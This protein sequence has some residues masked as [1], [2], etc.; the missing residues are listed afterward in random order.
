MALADLLYGQ[1]ENQA[2]GG[3]PAVPPGVMAAPQAAPPQQMQLPPPVVQAP[4]PEPQ[5]PGILDKLRSDPGITQAM[6]MMGAR[7]MQGPKQ[8]QDEYGALGD[9]AMIGLTAHNML[10]QNQIDN[11]LAQQEQ[12]RKNQLAD[13]QIGQVQA[14]TENI[15]LET[16][17]KKESFPETQKRVAAEI[18]RLNTSGEL[19][20]A[21]LLRE[22]Y[23]SDPK[24]L[25]E[26][27]DLD[28]SRTKAQITASNAS[29]GA[30]GAAAEASRANTELTK[31][32]TKAS[33]ELLDEG[34]PNAVLHGVRSGAGAAKD[35]L[36]GLKI[37][38]KQAWPEMTDAD[39]AKKAL[40]INSSKK[41]EDME[42]LKAMLEYGTKE[43]QVYAQEKLGEKAGVGKGTA[44]KAIPGAAKK[45]SPEDFAATKAANPGMSDEALK[46]AL[47]QR[48]FTF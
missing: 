28:K 12:T 15:Q 44:L 39:I 27:W 2:Q 46:A 14:N 19:D 45:V 3:I 13:A 32:K 25:A 23:R 4:A 5:A 22:Q 8:G 6:M 29:A 34:D 24:R 37:T 38:L 47:K 20:Q 16:A 18:K 36:A 33:Q 43:Q 17:Q 26:E 31:T 41:G 7:L 42:T 40:E 11:E 10:K 30:S 21:K 35:Q 48:G 9:A 1:G